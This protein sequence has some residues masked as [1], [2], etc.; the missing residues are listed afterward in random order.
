MA[1]SPDLLISLVC[2]L[3][4]TLTSWKKFRNLLSYEAPALQCYSQN[5]KPRAC[6]EQVSVSAGKAFQECHLGFSA[7]KEFHAV[8]LSGGPTLGDRLMADFES[9]HSEATEVGG[10][11]SWGNSCRIRVIRSFAGKSDLL[12]LHTRISSVSTDGADIVFQGWF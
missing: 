6:S 7:L 4:P 2:V 9:I 3:I 1:C 5:P 11:V 12:S 10:G 8:F